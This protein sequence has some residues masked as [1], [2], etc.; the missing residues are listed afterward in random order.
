MALQ[1]L[2]RSDFFVPREFLCLQQGFHNVIHKGLKFK[3]RSKFARK[4]G[5]FLQS[6]SLT[7]IFVAM[8]IQIHHIILRVMNCIYTI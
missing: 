4:H 2:L 3:N 7:I 5:E 1:N 6:Q 8:N